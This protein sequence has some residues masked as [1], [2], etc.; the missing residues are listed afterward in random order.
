MTCAAPPPLTSL[1][2]RS[3]CQSLASCAGCSILLAGLDAHQ[4][5]KRSS[6][7]IYA[8]DPRGRE[9]VSPFPPFKSPGPNIP[10]APG[11]SSVLSQYCPLP[12]LDW[13]VLNQCSIS[14]CCC[15]LWIP[16]KQE[17]EGCRRASPLV[18]QSH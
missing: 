12:R 10:W 16:F 18:H 1:R 11:G 4:S 2:S 6:P 15:V 14:P 13:Q 8:V 7:H 17:L 9:Q 3:H 5:H